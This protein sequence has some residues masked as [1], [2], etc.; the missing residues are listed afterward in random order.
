MNYGRGAL[1]GIVLTSGLV[2]ETTV[3]MSLI[4]LPFR[5]SHICCSQSPSP[6]QW[7]ITGLAT[8]IP[9]VSW[10]AYHRYDRLSHHSEPLHSQLP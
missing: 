4:N 10:T 3:Y 1:R 9:G 2:S 7:S 5:S 8:R 6:M